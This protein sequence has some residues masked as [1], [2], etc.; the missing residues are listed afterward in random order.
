MNENRIGINRSR[1]YPTSPNAPQ[2][3]LV[4]FH[5]SGCY[6]DYHSIVSRVGESNVDIAVRQALRGAPFLDGVVRV[7]M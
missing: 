5:S 3:A 1:V 2:T 7:L 4:L 6:P